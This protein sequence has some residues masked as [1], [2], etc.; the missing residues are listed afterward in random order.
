M[1]I[2]DCLGW[3][4]PQMGEAIRAILAFLMLLL[5]VLSI[6]IFVPSLTPWLPDAILGPSCLRASACTDVALAIH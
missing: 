1:M 4:A 5:I 3:F 6:I 2:R